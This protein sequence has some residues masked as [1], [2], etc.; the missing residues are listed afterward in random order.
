MKYQSRVNENT[1]VTKKSGLHNSSMRTW[2]GIIILVFLNYGLS[3]LNNY[4][5]DDF[6][7][8]VKNKFTQQGFGGIW[9]II[10][11]DSFAGMTAGN[12]AGLAG[13]RYRPLSLVTFAVE[14][15]FFYGNP[16]ISHLI[17]VLL[18]TCACILL[19]K[20]LLMFRTK[21]EDETWHKISSVAALLFAALPVHSES[22][23]N[24]KGRDDL[25]CLVFFLL[26]SIQ[27]FRY[28][29]SSEPKQLIYAL[30]FYFL[31]L[32]GKETAV[33][34]VAV[35]PLSI[36][37]F[38]D[39]GNRKTASVTAMFAA[40]AGLFLLIRY[41][42]TI[43]NAGMMSEDVLNNHFIAASATQKFATIL[44]TW[45]IYFKLLLFPLHLSY[46]YNYNEIPL[47]DFSNPA[48]LLSIAIHLTLLFVA[49][50]HF[51]RRTVYAY[52]IFFYFITFSVVSNLFMNTGTPLAERF[53]FIPGIGF[54]LAAAAF[55]VSLTKNAERS[56]KAA[57]L[58]LLLILA[59]FTIRNIIRCYDWKDN[60]TL[61]LADVKQTPNS[62]KS[63]LNAGIAC[64]NL[65]GES[66]GPAKEK[67][68][69]NSFE[70]LQKGISIYPKKIDGY[71]N[72]GVGYSWKGDFENAEVCWNRARLLFPESEELRTPYKV[73]SDHYFRKGLQLGTEKDYAASIN[74]ML[75]ALRYDSLN[76]EILFNLGGA[77][78]TIRNADSAVFYF[79]K[80]IQLDPGHPNAHEGLSA[81]R[82]LQA[83]K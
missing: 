47:T 1:N 27:L 80:T 12:V 33:T 56:Q 66:T 34:F 40:I 71:I 63:Q 54:C 79:Q 81:A 22:V 45:L 82:E 73:L 74:S 64:L 68:I 78:F 31:S 57:G 39:A 59:G 4:A 46:D 21:Y 16:F 9:N 44:L 65:A 29:Y 11:N 28:L 50:Y 37:F 43:E 15:Q 14:Q 42:A 18:Y 67:W 23:I 36:L 52:C 35:I 69:D 10:S 61:F 41:L 8:I 55:A 3:V 77:Y 32:L 26:S 49:V 2:F 7:V 30:C 58:L 19:F 51:R 5:L 75:H 72:M 62:A 38:S 48:V 76:P 83:K 6:I 20:W 53:I 60:N 17:N 25:L 70:Y 13:I 24:I